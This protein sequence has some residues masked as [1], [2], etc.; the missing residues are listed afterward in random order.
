[1]PKYVQTTKKTIRIITLSKYNAHTSPLFKK[2]GLLKF[3]DICLL[4]E[5]KL[6]Y[7]VEN[8]LTPDYF[9]QISSEANLS[10]PGRHEHDTRNADLLRLPKV[11]HDFAKYSISNR[12][13]SVYNE[14]DNLFKDKIYTHSFNGYKNY[15]KASLL[16]NYKENCEIEN[17][18]NCRD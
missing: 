1:M 12:I 7:K 8:K 2:L 14:M 15:I 4:S 13:P 10:A 16:A 5:M 3:D 11:K 18:P 6:C 9:K 17:C